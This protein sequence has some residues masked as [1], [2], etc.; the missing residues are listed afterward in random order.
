VS[1]PLRHSWWPANLQLLPES[2]AGLSFAPLR[3][4][5]RLTR[6]L[7]NR[8]SQVRILSGASQLNRY[9]A[10]PCGFRRPRRPRLQTPECAVFGPTP[11]GTI[12]QPSRA[13][14]SAN[15]IPGARS[16][17]TIARSLPWASNVSALHGKRYFRPSAAI[18]TLF[19]L[20]RRVRS[21][22]QRRSRLG[23]ALR[24]SGRC[25]CDRPG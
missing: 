11:S 7:R 22:G 19:A 25:P 16:S 20:R 9:S 5:A 13:L 6:K 1:T 14:E 15:G 4:E 3:A 2:R 12:A 8:R 10:Q 17:L 23:L 18:S 24:H 21:R